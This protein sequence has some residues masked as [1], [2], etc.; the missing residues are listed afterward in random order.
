MFFI[1]FAFLSTARVQNSI[2]KCSGAGRVLQW[3]SGA[4][5]QLVAGLAWMAIVVATAAGKS[6]AE[7]KSS[8]LI[9]AENEKI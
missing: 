7:Y 2:V 1:I 8:Q 5:V 3:W 9:C 6:A 4:L